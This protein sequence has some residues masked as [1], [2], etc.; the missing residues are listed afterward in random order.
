MKPGIHPK[1]YPDAKIICSCGNSW[2]AG[3]TQPEIHTDVCSAC[4]PFYTGEQRIVDSAG[5]VD[6]FMKRLRTK[7]Q[8]RAKVRAEAETRRSEEEEARKARARGEET[9]E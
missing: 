8:I 4:H 5:Q 3:C 6:R 7:D 2:T 9:A 1:Y